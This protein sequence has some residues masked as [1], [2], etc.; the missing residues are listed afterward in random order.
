MRIL[1]RDVETR[2][3]LKLP[4]VGPWRYAGDNSTDVWC[5]AY[6]VDDGSVQIWILGNPIP[7]E[8]IEAAHNPDWLVIAH[9][10]AFEA[11]IEQR[12]LGPRYGWPVVPIERHRCTMAMA[13]ADAL[14]GKLENVAEALKLSVQKDVEGAKLMMQM[15]KPRKPRAGEDP[16]GTYWVDDPKKLERL[17]RYCAR[18][19][20]VERELYGRLRPLS[21]AEQKLWILDQAIN[22]RGFAVDVALAAAAHRIVLERK[23][24]IDREIAE[25]SDGRILTVN[26]IA[27]IEA[28][29]KD[30]GHNVS[31]IGK[32]S[33]SAVLA[34]NPDETVARVLRLR[35]EGGKA[36]ANKLETLLETAND[37]RLHDTLRFHGASTGR[38]T[39]KNFQPQNLTRSQPADLEATIAAVSSGDLDRVAA[40]GPPLEVVASL[41]RAM[42]W[43]EPG[44]TLVSADYSAIESRILAWLAGETWKLENYRK[45]DATGDPAL[46][47]YCVTASRILGRTVTPIDDADR[48]VGKLCDLGFG[49]GGGAGAFNRIAPDTGFSE[50]EVETFKRQWRDAHPN[51]KRYWADLHRTLLRAVR[52]CAPIE[53]KNLC[54]EMRDGNL[55]LSLPSGRELVYREAKIQP[56]E[57]SDQ[58]LYKDNAIG[59]WQDTRGWHGTYVENVVQAVARDVLAAALLRLEA[60]GYTIVLHVHDEIVAEVAEDFGS[61]EDFARIMVES[62]PWAEGSPLVAKPSRHKRYT[63]ETNG[64][65]PVTQADNDAINDGL[66]REGIEPIETASPAL[67]AVIADVTAAIA[68]D[69]IAEHRAPNGGDPFKNYFSGEERTGHPLVRYVYSDEQGAPHHRKTRTDTKKFWQEKRENGRWIKGAPA[70]KYLYGVCELL[71][72]APDAAIWI[73]EGEKDRDSLAALDL[74]AVTNPG[75][76]GK[77]NSDFTTEQLERWFKG[78]KVVYLLE[79][80]DPPGQR[81]L[82]IVA[83]ALQHLVGEIR[84]VT[85]RDLPATG[86]VTDWLELGHGKDELLARAEA[87]PKYEPDAIELFTADSLQTMVF[88]P[89]NFVVPGFIAEGLTLFAG[90]PKIGKSWLLLHAAWAVACGGNTLG[91][92]KVETGDVFYAALEDNKRRLSRRMTRLFGVAS[93]PS[94]LHFACQMKKLADGGL[95]QMK[96]WIKKARCP[97]LIIIDTLKMVRTPNRKDQNYYEADYES[98]RELRD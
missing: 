6:A 27:K 13:L 64:P 52:T 48:Q 59:K 39:G 16:S 47:P 87:E 77:W 67:V 26:Q 63:K 35:Q 45:F 74:L 12:L 56:G 50:T 51:I 42:I 57:Y 68:K 53:F 94:G 21:D 1:I 40:I 73:A 92:I 72:A 55:Y 32:R 8:W 80:N 90:K 28:F 78:R 93:W 85:F 88:T 82:E 43:A 11:A 17:K 65:A 24:A 4:E 62:P 10:D 22:R 71:A 79:D 3:K 15:S 84:I 20:E 83:R 34:R 36:S 70:I 49:F 9:N 31:G 75:G 76:A 5:V 81:H 95:D 58:I 37:D 69:A 25:L 2:S 96:R 29:L 19:V 41:S 86:D 60:A 44:K 61:P 14:P 23:T 66:R 46:E 98:V 30:H 54:A 97:R 7:P 33:V 89:I 91:G 38:W 18:D